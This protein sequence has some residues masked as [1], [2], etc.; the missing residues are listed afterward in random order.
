MSPQ[1]FRSQIGAAALRGHCCGLHHALKYDYHLQLRVILQGLLV[2]LIEGRL[3]INLMDNRHWRDQE[4]SVGACVKA[5]VDVCV[6]Q[7]KKFALF[8]NPRLKQGTEGEIK[9]FIWKI[10]QKK[11]PKAKKHLKTKSICVT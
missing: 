8:R 11:N 6:V 10:T 3:V 5:H 2:D 9:H 7:W 4:D 1:D